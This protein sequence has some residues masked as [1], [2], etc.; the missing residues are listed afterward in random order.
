ML[1]QRENA[2][3]TVGRLLQARRQR[4]GR[5]ARQRQLPAAGH[6]RSRSASYIRASKCS[7]MK[8]DTLNPSALLCWAPPDIQKSL[9]SSYVG[10]APTFIYSACYSSR[11]GRVPTM[12]LLSVFKV[13]FDILILR[14]NI[15]I[16]IKSCRDT[17]GN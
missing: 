8:H 9:H 7:R 2:L 6:A 4:A 14:Q 11:V 15:R 13:A 16:L 5:A 17:F 3:A 1:H 12:L 10:L